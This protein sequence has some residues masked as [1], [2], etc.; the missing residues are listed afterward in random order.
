MDLD[1]KD[2]WTLDVSRSRPWGSI[3]APSVSMPY[4]ES[5]EHL[6][7]RTAAYSRHGSVVLCVLQHS[8]RK[9]AAAHHASGLAYLPP[10]STRDPA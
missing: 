3:Q 7:M 1:Y 9:A 10:H 2:A 4:L 5:L 8:L 6:S